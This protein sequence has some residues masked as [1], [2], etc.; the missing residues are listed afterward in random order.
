MNV[1]NIEDCLEIITGFKGSLDLKLK[2]E[3][4]AIMH[5]IANQ[6]SKSVPLT[7][8]QYELI[9]QKLKTY[10]NQFINYG[11]DNFDNALN[12]TRYPLRNID[13]SKYIRIVEKKDTNYI[14]LRFPFSKKIILLVQKIVYSDDEY[15]HEKGSHEH[16]FLLNERNT[17][18]IVDTFKDKGFEIDETLL[19]YYEKIKRFED[20]ATYDTGIV[21]F[22]F[23][24]VHASAIN[25]ALTE[26]GQPCAENIVKYRDRS[27]VYG[28]NYFDNNLDVGL[29][30]SHVLVHQAV[31]R[32]QPHFFV[33]SKIWTMDNLI[34]MLNELD[35]YPL[36]VLL[37]EDRALEHLTKTHEKFK[38]I[39]PSS[40]ISV[41]LRLSS[42]KNNGFNEYV[43]T[44]ELNSPVDKHTKVVYTSMDKINKPL[45]QS[46]CK[47]RTALL[48]ES[49]RLQNKINAWLEEFD[50]II[51]YDTEMSQF[52]RFKK[53]KFGY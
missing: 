32:K 10:K 30:K 28:I 15:I 6:I 27:T 40:C 22:E 42:N 12:S 7:D 47:P 18:Y 33:D 49:R 36:V 13:R 24:N 53:P 43:K 34:G 38:N 25:L 52:L 9:K 45:L 3:D 37:N 26:L 35:R 29:A 5:S 50:F 1:L 8:R 48:L 31:V 23:R 19:D 11:I 17:Y 39:F 46:E 4:I 2:K 20:C 44:H 21:N 41:N 14:K 51:H 16:Y